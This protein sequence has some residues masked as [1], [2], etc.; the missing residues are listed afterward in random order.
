MPPVNTKINL[1]ISLRCLYELLGFSRSSSECMLFLIK[2]KKK[3][4]VR[5]TSR[6]CH[7]H[8]PQPFPDPKPVLV[9]LEGV[10]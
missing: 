5:E 2:K 3:K 8:K 10:F 1:R 4:K 6:E 7:N 9:S